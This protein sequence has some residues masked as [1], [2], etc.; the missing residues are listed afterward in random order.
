MP[1]HRRNRAMAALD[2]SAFA[3]IAF[4]LIIFF[5]LTTTFVRPAG[6]PLEIPAG[7]EDKKQSEKKNLTVSL[8]PTAIRYGE[9]GEAVTLDELRAR[10][11]KRDLPRRAEADRIVILDSA[12]TVKYQAYYE[13]VMVI[14]STGGVLALIDEEPDR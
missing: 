10:L 3:D 12:P 13:V 5:I 11:L 7:A 1:L 4:L 6:A 2:V 9:K 8:S 14:N